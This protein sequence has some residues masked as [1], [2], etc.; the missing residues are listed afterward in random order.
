MQKLLN[1]GK[2]E[3]ETGVKRV[4][5]WQMQKIQ[6]NSLISPSTL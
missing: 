2:E 1:E 3:L 5:Q 4:Q 6:Y